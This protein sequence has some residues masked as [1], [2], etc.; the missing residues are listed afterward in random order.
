VLERALRELEGSELRSDVAGPHARRRGGRPD[1]DDG[2]ARSLLRVAFA[3]LIWPA[4]HDFET[5]RKPAL[6]L[7]L[8]LPPIEEPEAGTIE[9]A[10]LTAGERLVTP[11]FA[12]VR[13]H[14]AC[15]S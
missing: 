6:R 15:V 14:A 5:R 4:P 9:P 11:M 1:G 10:I 13:L 2:A 7:G 12:D 3:R 8:D